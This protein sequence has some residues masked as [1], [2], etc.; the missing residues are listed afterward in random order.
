L[1]CLPWSGPCAVGVC[2]TTI[3]KGEVLRISLSSGAGNRLLF[4]AIFTLA[5]I[6]F[7]LRRNSFLL[8]QALHRSGSLG[9]M[10]LV[11]TCPG[12]HHGC[13]Q[14][15]FSSFPGVAELVVQVT[16][17]HLSQGGLS[18]GPALPSSLSSS[19]GLAF[20]GLVLAAGL[21]SPGCSP[22]WCLLPSKIVIII[23]GPIS[24][25]IR[26]HRKNPRKSDWGLFPRILGFGCCWFRCQAVSS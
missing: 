13:V 10:P 2:A 3:V 16:G 24:F 5:H 23:P 22:S 18:S 26:A 6:F 1:V 14:S 7:V 8:Q 4:F 21:K 25:V 9:S 19:F 15:E 11:L 12:C 20:A 17:F